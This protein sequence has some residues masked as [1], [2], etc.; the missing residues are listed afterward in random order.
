M[1]PLDEPM[2]YDSRCSNACAI[3]SEDE[4]ARLVAAAEMYLSSRSVLTGFISTLGNIVERGLNVIP[5]S[6]REE[7]TAKIHDAL[8]IAQSASTMRMDDEPGRNARP[9]T[10]VATVIGTGLGGGAGGLPSIIAELPVTTALMM[11]SIADIGRAYGERLDDP[12]FRQTCIEVFAYGS[13]IEDDEEELAFLM[14]RLGAAQ[15]ISKVTIRYAAALGP[16][17]AAMSVPAAGAVA[18]AAL[19]FAYMT[20]YQS[21]ARVLF[22]LLPLERKHD[23][24]MVRSCFAS[25]VREMRERQA[26]RSRAKRLSK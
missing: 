11:R 24:A 6:L 3:L 1:P 16:K 5:E 9:G 8:V 10:Y 2:P 12:L 4:F 7:I 13:P 19:N 25:V 26:A 18:G 23:P 22:T 21:V 20:F 14:T 15:M 17:I